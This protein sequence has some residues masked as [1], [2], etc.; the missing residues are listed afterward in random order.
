MFE[1]ATSL[2]SQQIQSVP[3]PDAYTGDPAAKQADRQLLQLFSQ[4]NR[5]LTL[6]DDSDRPWAGDNLC[7]QLMCK[8]N[9]NSSSKCSQNNQ[10][11]PELF[12]NSPLQVK[13]YFPGVK[14]QSNAENLQGACVLSSGPHRIL[15]VPNLNFDLQGQAADPYRLFSCFTSISQQQCLFETQT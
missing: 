11:D 14:T 8:F 6:L 7:D 3:P 10:Y 12:G 13:N 15:V 1:M 4:K 9:Q 2:N 5:W